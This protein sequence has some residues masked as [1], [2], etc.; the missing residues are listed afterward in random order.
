MGKATL[1]AVI[2]TAFSIMPFTSNAQSLLNSI[3]STAS[4]LA[5][6]ASKST[7]S[8]TSA[9]GSLITSLLGTNDVTAGSIEGTWSYTQPSLV[10]ESEDVLASVASSAIAQKGQTYLGKGLN[11]AGFTAG[12]VNIVFN[13]DSTTSISI[14]GKTV[15]GTYSVNG[16]TLT[17]TYTGILTGV[18][19][20][21]STNVKISDDTMQ[22]AMSAQKLLTLIQTVSA[23]ASSANTTLSTVTSLFGS[24]NGMYVG[25]QFSKQK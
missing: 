6:T 20:S 15:N 10:F 23:T 12:K 25:L 11:K 24:V 7:N 1:K 16:N 21:V 18:T 4:S 14:A 13:S 8:V 19:K 5:S 17:L 9:A 3:K 2:L 22:I